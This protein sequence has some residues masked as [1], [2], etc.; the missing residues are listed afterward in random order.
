MILHYMPH[1]VKMFFVLYFMKNKKGVVN[2][3]EVSG[4]IIVAV[5]I[6]ATAIAGAAIRFCMKYYEWKGGVNTDITSF[7]G[8]MKEIRNDIK[9]ILKRLPVDPIS[10]GSPLQLT[11][12]GVK[13]SN[14]IDGKAWAKELAEKL[15]NRI[16]DKQ[17]FEIYDLSIQFIKT[18]NRYSFTEDQKI[19]VK[20]AAYDNAVEED[21]V[22]DV[23]IIELRDRLL[24][25]QK[26]GQ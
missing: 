18:E 24:E 11:E 15:K 7:K 23:L 10:G 3:S 21:R 14:D 9:E 26:L 5:V 1:N 25:I 17:P 19:R 2:M 22:W 8:F 16:F 13:I 4:S 6:V 20:T 12:F